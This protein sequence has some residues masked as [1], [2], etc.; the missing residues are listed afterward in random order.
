MN[1]IVTKATKKTMAI[2]KVM[3]FL[4]FDNGFSHVLKLLVG[5]MEYEASNPWPKVFPCLKDVEF[6]ENYRFC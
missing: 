1:A 4:P 5:T 3:M 2:A 6:G